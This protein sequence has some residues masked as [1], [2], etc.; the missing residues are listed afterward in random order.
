MAFTEGIVR[1]ICRNLANQLRR[2][3][4]IRDVSSL[5][6]RALS[7]MG[8]ARYDACTIAAGAADTQ[9]RIDAMSRRLGVSPG[10]IAIS[11]WLRVDIARACS[12][13]TK[14][15]ECRLWLADYDADSQGYKTFCPNAKRFEELQDGPPVSSR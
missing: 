12:H 8:I 15:G 3:R 2:F 13:C 10:R 6:A 9:D 1:R 11:P 7:D 5:D 14:R 4:D